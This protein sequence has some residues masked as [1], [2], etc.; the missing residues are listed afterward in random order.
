MLQRARAA[1]P[2]AKSD[3]EALILWDI[4]QNKREVTRLNHIDDRL[5]DENDRED[6]DIA[7]IDGENNIEQADIAR[8]IQDQ[9]EANRQLDQIK[10]QL[11]QLAARP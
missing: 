5:D 3:E 4:E 8:V 11:M 10:K 2:D 1:Y 9:E 6:A 7:R